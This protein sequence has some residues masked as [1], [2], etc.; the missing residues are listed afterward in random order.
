MI[1]LG[2]TITLDWPEAPGTATA[3]TVT[4]TLPDGTV[5]GPF[6][7]IGNRYLYV[8][9]QVGRHSVRWFATGPYGAA[10]TDAFDVADTDPGFVIGLDEAK[11]QL[12]I[13]S[14][15]ADEEL[16]TWLGATTEVIEHYVGDVVARTH[17]EVHNGGGVHIA[18]FHAPI[19][20]VTSLTEYIGNMVYTLT[21]QPPGQSVSPYGFSVDNPSGGIITRRTVGSYPMAFMPGIGNIAITYTAGRLSVPYAVQGAARLI[22]QHLWT[23]RRGAMPLPSPGGGDVSV[24]PGIGYAVPTKAVELLERY[25]R[26]PGIA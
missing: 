6:T 18:T 20:S 9:T 23:T 24:V 17:T 16:R 22:V 21:N 8:P 5:T 10:F 4:V 26:Q 7:T 19:I 15:K 14:N 13:T 12:S 3:V 25:Q 2:D 1:D 11:E